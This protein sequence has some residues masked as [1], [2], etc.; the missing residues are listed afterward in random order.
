MA[1]PALL[2]WRGARLACGALACAMPL[3]TADAVPGTIYQND[4]NPLLQE[5]KLRGRYHGQF[6]S[7]VA[8]Q[9]EESDWEDR[10]SRFGFSAK[11]LQKSIELRADF[12]SNDGFR[13][14]YDGLVDA[15]LRWTP[16]PGIAV[17][18]GKM[19]PRIAQHDWVE[20]SNTQAT[21]ETSHGFNQLGVERAT[22]LVVDGSRGELSWRCGLHSNDTP[23][24]TQGSGAWGEGEFGDLQG[25]FSTTLGGG[26]D[27]KHALHF[28]K[29]ALFID[30]LHSE[31]EPGDR[32]LAKFDD[33]LS[34]TWIVQH[35]RAG[36]V[37]EGFHASGGD[38]GNG[39]IAGFYLLPTYEL[40]PARLELVA[41]YT[42]SAGRGDESLSAQRRYE[43]AAPEITPAG[44][45]RGDRYHALYL[46]L[47][48]FI[49]GDQLKLMAGTE[50]A[51]LAGGAVADD[52]QGLTFL[53]GIRCSF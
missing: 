15:F 20:S 7:V 30:W 6:W 48:Y 38:S 40:V 8:D 31:R 19:T 9:G 10:R 53:T 47:Q 21:F 35:D 11:F 1:P 22:G 50:Y 2:G 3:A 18:L 24:N 46:G 44:R 37:L 45:A 4:H 36:C 32:V 17:S 25:G 26:Y 27:F 33:I 43:Q 39:R 5:F 34:A 51:R 29:A 14:A 23:P 49:H 28:N 16:R 42:F 41:R 12:K 13:D 52:Y